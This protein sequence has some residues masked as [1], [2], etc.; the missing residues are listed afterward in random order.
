MHL[1]LLYF[2]I[3]IIVVTILNYLQNRFTIK[4]SIVYSIYSV[5][6]FSLFI[7]FWPIALIVN[8]L[9]Y[10]QFVF[11]KL[12]I[13]PKTFLEFLY[14]ISSKKGQQH[15]KNLLNNNVIDRFKL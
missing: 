8:L 13:Q 15:N 12:L 4:K 1:V 10:L 7:V 6:D 2:I 5:D 14:K 9:T 11:N 3:G